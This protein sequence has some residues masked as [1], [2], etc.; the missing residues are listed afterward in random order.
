MIT[1]KA[2]AYVHTTVIKKWDLLAGDAILRAMG[3]RL[4]TLNN[5]DIQYQDSAQYKIDAGLLATMQH[6]DH[7]LQ[8][9]ATLKNTKR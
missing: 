3:G 1:N 5:E 8:E 2:D 9:L 6:H 7:Y 4:T